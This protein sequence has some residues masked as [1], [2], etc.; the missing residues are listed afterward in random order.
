MPGGVVGAQ[1]CAAPYADQYHAIVVWSRNP[2]AFVTFRIV[3]KLGL[4]S[5]ESAL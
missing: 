1:P 4:P 3:P 5:P 2:N